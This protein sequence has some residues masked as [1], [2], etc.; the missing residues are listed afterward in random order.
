MQRNGKPKTIARTLVLTLACSVCLPAVLGAGPHPEWTL[1]APIKFG[2]TYLIDMNG[3]VIHTWPSKY[4]PGES[5]YLLDDGALLRTCNDSS[6]ISFGSAGAGGRLERIAWDGT[7][8]WSY[9]PGGE[10]IVPHHDVEVLPNGNILAIVWE[11]YTH[12]EAVAVG[13][14]PTATGD[15]VWSEA[16]LEIEPSGSTGGTVVWSWHVWDWLVQ[17]FDSL[18]PNYGEP[19]DFPGRIDINFGA[20][21]KGDWLHLN[22]I[23]YNAALDQIVVCSR[24]FDEIWIISHAPGDSGELLYRWGNPQAYGR[25]SAADQQFFDPHDPEWILDGLPGAGHLTVFNN[26]GNDRGYFSIDELAPPLN[27]NGTYHL[28]E[29]QPYGPESLTWTCDAIDGQ[30]FSS[31]AMGGVQ[32]LANGNT[33][34]CMSQDGRFIEVDDT[35]SA[36]WRHD[37]AT[38]VFRATRIDAR[39]PRLAGLLY[40]ESKRQTVE[41]H[42]KH[43][44][45]CQAELEQLKELSERLSSDSQIWQQTT[46]EDAVFSRIIHRQNEKLNQADTL[47]RQ[48]GIW[49]KIMKSKITKLAATACVIIA[50]ILGLN[51]I[52]AQSK[53]GRRD[54]KTSD[55]L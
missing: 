43:C 32:R 2:N 1:Y 27:S 5:V 29:D 18:L 21:N 33:L 12:E 34:V 30:Q 14:N 31:T 9:T 15:W 23:D 4:R 36:V 52:G 20:S 46:L 8:E 7:V 38:S 11:R 44:Q 35:C 17:D 40:Y 51:I 54:S 6:V 37:I 49:I 16:I 25:G 45:L 41:E 13:R 39:D 24:F 19:A 10:D 3:N 22:G 50:V 53:S 28:P 26:G 55:F 48:S 47:N 42:L